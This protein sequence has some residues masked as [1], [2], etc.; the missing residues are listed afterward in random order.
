M[1]LTS[2]L[3]SNQLNT[4]KEIPVKNWH[5]VFPLFHSQI[6]VMH[7]KEAVHLILS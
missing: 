5:S 7:A 6:H 3:G 1:S 2:F 4:L